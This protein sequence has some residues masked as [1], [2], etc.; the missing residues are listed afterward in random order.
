MKN[1]NLLKREKKKVEEA[2]REKEGPEVI[3]RVLPGALGTT[4][5]WS[6]MEKGQ[7][8]N[9]ACWGWPEAKGRGST[10][11]A[12]KPAEKTPTEPPHLLPLLSLSAW[13]RT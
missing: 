13:S 2:Y 1:Q 7:I 4:S 9:I 11:W 5:R 6:K 3:C 12:W 8:K 10:P